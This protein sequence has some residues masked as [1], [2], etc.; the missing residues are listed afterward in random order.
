MINIANYGAILNQQP[1]PSGVIDLEDYYTKEEVD[2]KLGGY[3]P[4]SGGRLTGL[5]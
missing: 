1:V 2:S 3:L 4:L 5:I